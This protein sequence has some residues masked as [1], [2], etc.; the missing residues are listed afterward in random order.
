MA[1]WHF[2]LQLVPRSTRPG[3]REPW[4][5]RQPAAGWRRAVEA[6]LARAPSSRRPLSIWGTRELS[7]GGTDDGTRIDVWEH[8]R[9]VESIVVRIDTREPVER[10]APFCLDLAE[11]AQAQGDVV[12]TSAGGRVVEPTAAALSKA[13]CASS[14]W[15]FV[16]DEEFF[17]GPPN[18]DPR[19]G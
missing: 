17:G 6:F 1:S 2:N 10:L 4:L 19:Y 9:R 15:H 5:A 7:I 3:D 16:H 18:A 14:A 13:I 12:F 11:L 8:E